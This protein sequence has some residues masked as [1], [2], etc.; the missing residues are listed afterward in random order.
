MFKKWLVVSCNEVHWM[1]CIPS[2]LIL[3]TVGFKCR[4]SQYLY[5]PWNKCHT[6]LPYNKLNNALV[7][8]VGTGT[9]NCGEMF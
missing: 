3:Q 8:S 7:T 5:N 9:Q 1:L 4:K 2:S 6:F